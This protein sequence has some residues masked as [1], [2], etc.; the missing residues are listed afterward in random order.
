[1]YKDQKVNVKELNHIIYTKITKP[2]C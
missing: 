1:M 2:G